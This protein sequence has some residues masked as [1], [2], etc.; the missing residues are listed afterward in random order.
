M[1]PSPGKPR[2]F[3]GI[4]P[5]GKLHLGNYIG[6]LSQWVSNQDRSECIYSI[7]DFHALTSVGPHEPAPIAK[8]V[9][10]TAA[11]LIAC[12][13]DPERSA[14]FVQS[15]ISA[16]AELAWIL[17][18]LTPVGWLERMT[19]YKAKATETASAT[20][21]LLTYPVLQ[22]ADILLYKADLV[23]VGEDQKQHIELAANLARRFNRLFGEVFV[24]PQPL[25]RTTGARLMALD[26]PSIKMSKSFAEIRKGHAIGLT[27]PPDL[28]RQTVMEAVTD[29]GSEIRFE[30][31]SPGVRNLLTI[32]EAVTGR[33]R[34][35]I[36]SHF[37]S[38]GYRVLKSEVADLVIE[39]LKPIRD[40]YLELMD[41]PG[42]LDQV[43]RRG[44]QRVLPIAFSTL[45]AVKR[46][47]GIECSQPA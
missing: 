16:H 12:G 32:F 30:Q 11:L 3:S 2:I 7:V 37:S 1:V 47:I 14:L 4:Q 41:D 9:T 22:S 38:R 8:R 28:I 39:T 15:H 5:T 44:A 23:P 40:R 31:A 26:D 43:L 19:Q 33:P 21:G 45:D 29:S 35:E 27:D 25:V 24:V 17:N 36:E 18:C 46:L 10:Q 42:L 34:P 20:A 13:L 6:A